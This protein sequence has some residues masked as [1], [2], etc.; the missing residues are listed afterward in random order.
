MEKKAEIS[1]SLMHPTFLDVEYMKR[2]L[3]Q[4]VDC[5]VDS[6]EICAA[7]HTPFGGMDGLVLY[8]EYPEVAASL[9][10]ERI[11]ATRAALQQIVDLAHAAGKPVYYWHREVTVWPQF[12]V[13]HG[14]ELL[15][16]NREFNLFGE[17]FSRLLRYKI[18]RT[19][20]AVPDL[21]GLVLT[22]TEA[23][24][25]AIHHSNRSAYPPVQ[26]VASLA[27]LFAGELQRRG[28]RFILRSFGS[29]AQ[30][31]EDILAG[32]ALAAADYQFE[33]ET[34]IT[35]YDFVP[36]LPENP[37]MEAIPGLSL[38]A[39]CDSLG[40]FLGAG[41][42]PAENVANIVKY[43][44]YAQR[45]GVQRYAIRLDRVGNSIFTAYPINLYAYQR[46]IDDPQVTAADICR[47]YAERSYPP[48]LRSPLLS[49]GRQGYE[50]VTRLHYIQG[51]VMFHQFPLKGEL[52]VIKAG[53]IFALFAEHQ[54]LAPLA[55]IWSI[56]SMLTTG[57]RADI[58]DEKRE[59]LTLARAGAAQV[60]ALREMLAPGEYRRLSRLWGNAEL[61][62]LA[63]GAFC[64]GVCL[65]CDFLER[66]AD[67][68]TFAA[69]LDGII[70]TQLRPLLPEGGVGARS[71]SGCNGMDHDV[72]VVCG[73]DMEKVYLRPIQAILQLLPGEYQAELAGRRAADAAGPAVD[74]LVF[75]AI[76]QDGRCGRYMHGSHAFLE[77]GRLFRYVGNPVF[78]NGFLEFT[79]R[80]PQPGRYRLVLEAQGRLRLTVNGEASVHAIAG[81][82]SLPLPEGETYSIVLHKEGADFPK[83]YTAALLPA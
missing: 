26:V 44:R 61:A 2:V 78:P 50:L 46:A 45:K 31:Y 11:L 56:L 16:E 22:L 27:R 41:Y 23:D 5:R 67:A 47:E 83:I 62:A 77:N 38:S 73:D 4:A 20:A 60:E 18:D 10:R 3:G 28:K 6:F 58:L 42:L 15:D 17:A 35:P 21:D 72:F 32:A 9:D 40:E 19:F 71:V 55:G 82:L 37:F 49:L 48:C 7:C 75:G 8:E 25:S 36:F 64:E 1:W 53:G 13:A 81:R 51:N 30:D 14:A 52:K 68:A 70:G 65:Y 29:V 24:F 80:P 34:K 79:L 63:I 74:S 54:Q 12:L 39:E 59:A 76:S 33:I 43:V 66:V 69:A 57:S